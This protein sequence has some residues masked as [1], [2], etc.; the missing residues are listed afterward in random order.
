MSHRLRASKV[1]F[2]VAAGMA[3]FAPLLHD[4]GTAATRDVAFPGW[5]TSYEGRPLKALPLSERDAAF[6]RDFPG[7]IGRFHDGQHAIIIRYLT[8]PTRRLHPASD[9]LRGVGY[10]ITALPARR[11]S[12]GVVTSCLKAER[13]GQTL[14]VCE[15]VRST[16]G[17]HWPDVSS[18]YW[19][20][21]VQGASG[22]WWS[23][24]VAEDG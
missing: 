3:A 17:D 12:S 14:T 18:W 4:D 1:S 7:H 22:P 13:Q 11:T 10:S 8:E 23:F 6:A 19:A 9:C 21:L 16:R 5:P 20:A 24:V 15:S 2:V